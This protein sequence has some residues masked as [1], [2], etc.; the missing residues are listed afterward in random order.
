MGFTGRIR[1]PGVSLLE[2]LDQ[3][4]RL[5]VSLSLH[6]ASAGDGEGLRPGGFGQIVA[7]GLDDPQCQIG[8]L[9]PAR[10]G[11]RQQQSGDLRP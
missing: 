9:P 7:D 1:L 2:R 10:D 6:V 5:R 3:G 4:Q 8:I 11:N